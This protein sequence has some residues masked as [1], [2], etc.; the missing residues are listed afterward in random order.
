MAKI[1]ARGDSAAIK[2]R[3]QDGGLVVLTRRGRL[4]E[5]WQAGAGYTVASA[6]YGAM[7]AAGWWERTSTLDPIVAYLIE[8][9]YPGAEVVA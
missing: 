9:R 4:L 5:Q 1:S 3:K 8:N 6:R 7:W 2:L